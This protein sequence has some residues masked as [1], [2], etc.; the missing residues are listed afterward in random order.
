MRENGIIFPAFLLIIVAIIRLTFLYTRGKTIRIMIPIYILFFGTLFVFIFQVSPEYK[1]NELAILTIIAMIGFI[2]YWYFKIFK[3]SEMNEE[4]WEEGSYKLSSNA[5]VYPVS[6]SNFT[7]HEIWT[8][9]KDGKDSPVLGGVYFDKNTSPMVTVRKVI[10]KNTGEA[11]Y[12]ILQPFTKIDW[13]EIAILAFMILSVPL[14]YIAYKNG[15]RTDKSM[16]P[17]D[18]SLS[19]VLIFTYLMF[20]VGYRALKQKDSFSKTFSVIFKILFFIGLFAVFGA[21]LKIAPYIHL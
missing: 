11:S 19:T 2:V 3:N 10:D 5:L 8:V 13:M 9:H 1:S 21:I 7:A 4:V 12:L 17:V 16:Y 14:E 6:K 18:V 15:L 20:W